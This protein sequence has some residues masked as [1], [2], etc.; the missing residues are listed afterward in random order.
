MTL[1]T[2]RGQAVDHPRLVRRSDFWGR[3]LLPVCR[4]LIRQSGFRIVMVV[5][6]PSVARR[7]GIYDGIYCYDPSKPTDCFSN[8]CGFYG[9]SL[10]AR[11]R[12][13]KSCVKEGLKVLLRHSVDS[14]VIEQISTKRDVRSSGRDQIPAPLWPPDAASTG[15]VCIGAIDPEQDQGDHHRQCENGDADLEKEPTVRGLR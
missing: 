11:H 10:A 9:R 2:R 12:R 1:S 15:M 5:V 4:A 6:N 14:V 7:V 3:N 13:A 8:G